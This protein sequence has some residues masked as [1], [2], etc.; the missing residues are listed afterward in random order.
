MRLRLACSQAS[1]HPHAKYQPYDIVLIT[2]AGYSV[3]TLAL[4]AELVEYLLVVCDKLKV[5]NGAMQL[6][7]SIA[8]R[9]LRR[10]PNA[11]PLQ[12]VLLVSLLLASKI[13]ESVPP[14]MNDLHKWSCNSFTSKGNYATTKIFI[15]LREQS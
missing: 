9:F 8:C 15:G 10:R 6:G 7:L 14:N 4:P 1:R 2:N 13:M 3:S 12:L 5:G 11:L